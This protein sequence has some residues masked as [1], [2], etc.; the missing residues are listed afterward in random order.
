MLGRLTRS[1][2]LAALALFAASCATRPVV[3][4][5]EK[6]RESGQVAV[7]ADTNECIAEAKEYLRSGRVPELARRTTGGAVV[8]GAVGA[9]VGAV[10]G[11]VGRG[12]AAGAAGGAAGGLAHG[13]WRWRD[14]DPVERAYVNRCL[15]ERG[16]DVIGWR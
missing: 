6:L 15:R 8:G 10:G 9:A 1:V 13:L 14:P 2:S 3:Y 16:Y 7:E 5:N 4:P 11:S 12:A